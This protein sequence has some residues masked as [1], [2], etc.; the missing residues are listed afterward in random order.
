MVNYI[1][2]LSQDVLINKESKTCKGYTLFAPQ[3]DKI[4]WLVDMEGNICHYWEMEHPPGVNYYLNNKGN[5]MWL[6]RGEEAIKELGGC[7]S[8]LLE[9]DWEGNEVWRYD[10]P[11]LHHDFKLMENGNIMIMRF[12]PL[13][14]SVQEKVKGGA[15]GTELPDGKMMGIQIQE[16]TRDKEVVWEWSNWEHFDY[17]I[18]QECELCN[19]LS[20]GYTNSV[21]VFPNGDPVIS[22]RELNKIIRISKKTGDIVWEIGPEL[23]LG[24]QHDV[25]VLPNGNIT[26]FD[27]GVHRVPRGH[28]TPDE[29]ASFCTSRAL[30]VD[31][32]KPEIVWEYIDPTHMLFTN[33]CGSTQKLSNGNYFI[34]ESRTGTFYEITQ[35]KEVVW[36]YVSPFTIPRPDIFGWTAA[37]LIFQAHRYGIDF[38]GFKG[39]DLDPD[40]YEWTINKKDKKEMDEEDM[41]R[42]RLTRAG[43]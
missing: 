10:D 28:D 32:E 30:E 1:R 21:D 24:H 19:R 27:N 6:G 22:C 29:I 25:D 3:F 13:E 5:L 40:Q 42:S 20:W 38:E 35:E 12:E 43:Y 26:L 34:C 2:T 31:P 18:H 39:K 14:V 23:D 7:A 16:L 41:I 9:V 11:K 8:Y 37:K 15:P 36:K 4:A 33:F 17:D